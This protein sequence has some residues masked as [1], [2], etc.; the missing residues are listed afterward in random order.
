MSERKNRKK[1]QKQIRIKNRLLI[2]LLVTMIAV[3]GAFA[4]NI[5]NIN[6]KVV[7]DEDDLTSTTEEV[8]PE[9]T[10]DYYSIGNN[11]TELNKEYFLALNESLSNGDVTQVSIDVVKCFITEYYTWTNKDGNY[12]VGGMQYIYTDRQSDFESY[13]R[14][15]F[16]SDMD[17]LLTQLGR[18]NLIQV[19]S[20]DAT[21]TPIDSYTVLN[22]NGEAVAYPA[23]MVEAN[24]TYEDGAMANSYLTQSSGFFYVINHDGRME[25][26]AI[27]Q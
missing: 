12:D 1:R 3:V 14:N 25:I 19:A 2:A 26:A 18:E 10:N 13:T 15:N 20:V 6:S 23:F 4:Y 9:Y 8:S 5:H 21:A 17:A 7:T 11:A 24:W 27:T 22:M 16:Y